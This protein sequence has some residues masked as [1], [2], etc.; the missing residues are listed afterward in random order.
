MTKNLPQAHV[1]AFSGSWLCVSHRPVLVLLG[2]DVKGVRCTGENQPG[3]S[4][5]NHQRERVLVSIFL[6]VYFLELKETY[7]DARQTGCS[8]LHSSNQLVLC[9]QLA[10]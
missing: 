6:L 5:L 10:G 7:F 3:K 8:L 2:S 4:T 9:W 1:R